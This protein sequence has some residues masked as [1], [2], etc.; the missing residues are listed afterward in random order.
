MQLSGL[1]K[2]SNKNTE[3]NSIRICA[4]RKIRRM[5]HIDGS[6]LNRFRFKTGAFDRLLDILPLQLLRLHGQYLIRI[7]GIHAPGVNALLPVKE[8]SHLS[9]AVAAIDICFETKGFHHFVFWNREVWIEF[10]PPIQDTSFRLDKIGAF[11][12]HAEPGKHLT[13]EQ[14]CA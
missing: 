10:H 9:Q 6:F 5:P 8:R 4:L 2:I 1:K 11:F 14:K 7:V 12:V 13:L 3:N